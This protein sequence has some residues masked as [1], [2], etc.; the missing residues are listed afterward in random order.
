MAFIRREGAR[1]AARPSPPALPPRRRPHP[2]APPPR[3]A[4][5]PP[6]CRR[7]GAPAAATLRRPQVTARRRN[8]EFGPTLF[9]AGTLGICE[10]GVKRSSCGGRLC[11]A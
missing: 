11:A 7:I 2:P 5:H 1:R 6:P 4:R 10:L 9:L 8:A 3:R